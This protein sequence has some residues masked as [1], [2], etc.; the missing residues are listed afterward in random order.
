MMN[1]KAKARQRSPKENN[2]TSFNFAGGFNSNEIIS[3][4]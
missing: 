4:F 3:G 1:N 2:S